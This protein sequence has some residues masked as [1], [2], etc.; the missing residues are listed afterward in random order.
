[1]IILRQVEFRSCA[2]VMPDVRVLSEA[3][4]KHA[5]FAKAATLAHRLHIFTELLDGQVLLSF[6]YKL[7]DISVNFMY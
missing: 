4:L 2:L 6:L 1:M 7:I 5:G 3:M